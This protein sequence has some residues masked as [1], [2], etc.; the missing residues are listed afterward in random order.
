MEKK[1]RE[2][3]VARRKRRRI[4]FDVYS[5]V[6]H[7]QGSPNCSIRSVRGSREIWRTG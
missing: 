7:A 5:Q 6:E 1:S 2:K 4:D 3:L